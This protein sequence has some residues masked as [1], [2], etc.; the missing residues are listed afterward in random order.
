MTIY[1]YSIIVYSFITFA[2]SQQIDKTFVGLPL[3]WGKQRHRG[4][5]ENGPVVG[6]HLGMIQV[7]FQLIP[8]CH[9]K[10]Q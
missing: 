6:D 1:V 2:F 9:E 5:F 3:Q 8:R 7:A 4:I 10:I